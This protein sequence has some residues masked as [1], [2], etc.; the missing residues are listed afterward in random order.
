MIQI[1]PAFIS[2]QTTVKGRITDAGTF[3]PVIFANVIFKGTS[4]GVQTDFDGNFTLSGT[5]GSDSI[6]ISFIGYETRTIGIKHGI[7]QNLD[8]QL[9]PA[10][11]TTE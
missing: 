7:S 6:I 4:I 1:F 10:L 9:H 5:T 2:G 3:E 11:Y 8:V